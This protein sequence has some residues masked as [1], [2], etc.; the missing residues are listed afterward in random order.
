MLTSYTIGVVLIS[1]GLY[2]V[3]Q[4]GVSKKTSKKVEDIN[5]AE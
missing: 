3:I 1:I 2:E 4:V 5:D